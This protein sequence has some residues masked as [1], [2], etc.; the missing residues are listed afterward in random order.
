[1]VE[2]TDKKRLSLAEKNANNKQWFK[3]QADNLKG[4]AF[5]SSIF[6]G[7]V[8]EYKRKKVNY[9]LHNGIIDVRDFEYV[10]KP[11]GAEAGELPASFTN[12]DIVSSRIKA[13]E[14]MEMKR[15]FSWKITATNEEATTRKEQEEFS[16]IK[17]YVVQQTLAPIRQQIELKYQEQVQGKQLTPEEQKQI[18]QQI[19][20]EL[21]AQTPEEVRKYMQRKHQDPAEAL[22]HQILQYLIQ[23]QDIKRKFSKGWKHGMLGGEIVYWVGIVNG[24]PT[25]L[26]TNSIRFDYDKSPDVDF[27]EDG[28]W[29]VAEYRMTPS[30]VV[31]M[32]GSELK[33]TEIDQIYNENF[34]GAALQDPDF[35]FREVSEEGTHTVTVTHC[36]WKALRKIG[37]LTYLDPNTGKKEIKQVSEDYVINKA[38]GDMSIEW[39]WIPESYETYIIGNDIYAFMRPVPGQFKDLEDLY[40]CKLSYYG[41]AFDNLNSETTSLM[42]RMKVWQYYYNI[43][44]YRLEL[45]MASDKG[46]ILMMNI[47]GIPKSEGIDVEKWLYYAEA[48]KIGWVNPDEEGNRGVDVTN[49]AKEINMSLISD[50]QKYVE[51][52]SYIDEQCGKSVGITDAVLGQVG[53]SEAV[54]NTRQNI[55]QTS[56]IL[57]PYF[58]LHNNIKRNVLQALIEQAKIAYSEQEGKK[59]SYVLD[60]LSVEMVNV[61]AGLLDSSTFGVF[62]SNTSKAHEAV[63]LVKQMAHAAMQNQAINLSDV[64]KVIRTDGIQEAEEQLAAS[65]EAKR[66]QVQEDQLAVVREQGKNDEAKRGFEREKMEFDRETNLMIED[67]K[68]ER[69]LA[70]QAMLSVGFNEDK[71][72]D[73]DGVPDVMEIYRNQRDANFKDRKQALDERKFEHQKEQDKVKNKLEEKKINKQN[74]PKT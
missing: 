63:E 70:K 57:E 40:N 17:D 59:L 47:K 38:L 50:I 15:P 25:V 42:D 10:C 20:Q 5:T 33:D 54:S 35:S 26:V 27:I 14:G 44:M 4:M 48:L 3:N 2:K 37:F 45:L 52:A 7:E 16:L 32:F 29:A 74:K 13:L 72:I 28:E 39:Q 68:T 55:V 64:I 36:N 24:E 21:E 51:L 71:D 73:K 30:Q 69:D 67:K 65:E 62:V 56:Y 43:I 49:M 61:D 23:K 31:S 19:A 18:Q 6:N 66:R 12:K 8:S 9:D 46:K 1:M 22:S 60:D 58:D 34:M 41:G 53:P 11:F